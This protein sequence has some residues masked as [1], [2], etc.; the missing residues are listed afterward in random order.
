M[1]ISAWHTNDGCIMCPQNM[2][3]T[4]ALRSLLQMHYANHRVVY[5]GDGR[6]DVCPCVHVECVEKI[7]ARDDYALHEGLK[8]RGIQHT[9]WKDA[10]HLA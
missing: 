3:K 7:F 8:K 2:C 4:V 6:G 10:Q 5:V 1:R 9:V